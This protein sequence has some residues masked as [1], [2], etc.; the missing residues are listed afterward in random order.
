MQS[1]FCSVHQQSYA[2]VKALKQLLRR[3]TLNRANQLKISDCHAATLTARLQLI[4]I[5]Q[6]GTGSK[7]QN[8]PQKGA[9]AKLNASLASFRKPIAR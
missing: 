8:R 9:P 4:E 3:T 6:T 1:A 5:I 2:A 7:P